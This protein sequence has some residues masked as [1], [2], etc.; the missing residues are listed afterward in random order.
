LRLFAVAEGSLRERLRWFEE[1]CS[2]GNNRKQPQ[3]TANNRQLPSAFLLACA[4]LP[5]YLHQTCIPLIYHGL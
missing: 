5:A 3:T 2:T 1:L 4:L